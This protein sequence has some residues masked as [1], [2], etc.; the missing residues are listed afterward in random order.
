[1]LKWHDEALKESVSLVV[2]IF[3]EELFFLNLA[4]EV[5]FGVVDSPVLDFGLYIA[6]WS[7]LEV[8]EVGDWLVFSLLNHDCVTVLRVNFS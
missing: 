5:N 4:T 1:M 8:D 3:E 6:M 2:N 7:A